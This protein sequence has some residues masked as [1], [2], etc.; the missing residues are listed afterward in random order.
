M[1][2][3]LALTPISKE[4]YQKAVVLLTALAQTDTSGGRAAAQAVLSAY[5]GSDWQL[6]VTDLC[7]LDPENYQAALSVIRGRVELGIEPHRLIPDGDQVF[8]RIWDRW[9]RYHLENR[10]KQTCSSCWGR[11]VHV[12]YD[13]EDN[14]IRTPCRRCNGTGLI[15]D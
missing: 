13:D 14:E 6:D 2:V 7:V 8:G 4:E 5:N 11:G 10:W 1:V 15:A 9:A 12:D 3:K